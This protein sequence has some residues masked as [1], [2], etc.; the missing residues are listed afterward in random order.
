MCKHKHP[1]LAYLLTCSCIV[2]MRCTFVTIL[3]CKQVWNIVRMCLKPWVILSWK[4]ILAIYPLI[5]LNSLKVVHDEGQ[6][7]LRFFS[8]CSTRIFLLSIDPKVIC[9]AFPSCTPTVSSYC[10]ISL[11]SLE[12]EAIVH[13]R[14]SGHCSAH[15]WSYLK[16]PRN[17]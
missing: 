4:S 13:Y 9:I 6:W 17:D 10:I 16:A 7:Q 8:Y 14:L 2:R 5:F 1:M 12:L 11:D 3:I 15:H